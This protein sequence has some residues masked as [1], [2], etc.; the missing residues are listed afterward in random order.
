[1]N[2]PSQKSQNIWRA[3][4]ENLALDAAEVHVWRA[5]LALP[6]S[7]VNSLSLLLAPDELGRAARFHFRR[8]RDNF[9]AARGTLRV[10]LARYLGVRPGQLEF[11]YTAYDKPSL[12]PESGGGGDVRFNLSHSHDLALY[13]FTLG[14]EVGIDLEHTRP[15]EELDAIAG[16][17]FSAP[18]ISALRA[19][20][21]DLRLEA[22]YNC[23][24][25][26]EAYIKAR[27]EGLSFPLD[28]FAV[29]VG[30]GEGPLPLDV[31][32]CPQES[33]RWSLRELTPG[34]GYAA[35]IAVEGSGWSLKC[36]GAGD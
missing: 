21:A 6:A 9:I 22:F 12:A 16:R 18:E 20:P 28:C 14:R 32:G 19:L 17:F 1:M 10:I 26:K 4:P 30:S 8:D 15:Q 34:E 23:W 25:R 33:A 11:R 3:P 7:H 29:S 35:A 13:A 5:P 31:F 27:G 2:L 24:T 36:W